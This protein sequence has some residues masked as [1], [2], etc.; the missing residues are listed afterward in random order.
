[1]FPRFLRSDGFPDTIR[2]CP[3]DVKIATATSDD[4]YLHGFLSLH[5]IHPPA[6]K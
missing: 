2:T 5:E 3:E 1:M 6:G 4:I